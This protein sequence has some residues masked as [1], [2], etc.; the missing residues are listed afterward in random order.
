V[1]LLREQGEPGYAGIFDWKTWWAA[2]NKEGTVQ[3]P[4]VG[5]GS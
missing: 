1:D 5:I 3:Y 2:E 4:L